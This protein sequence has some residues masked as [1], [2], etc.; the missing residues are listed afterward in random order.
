[1]VLALGACS[2]SHAL[3]GDD[4]NA[5]G[6]FQEVAVDSDADSHI[7]GLFSPGGA[8]VFDDIDFGYQMNENA[9]GGGIALTRLVQQNTVDVP[10]PSTL[11]IFALGIMGLALRRFKKQ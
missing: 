2:G 6:S 11:A 10:E 4:L 1:M 7:P 9:V 5:N 3:F 8:Y